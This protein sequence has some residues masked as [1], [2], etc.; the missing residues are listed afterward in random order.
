[1]LKIT[2]QDLLKLKPVDARRKVLEVYFRNGG[3][4]SRTSREIGVSRKTVRK[5]VRRYKEK[6][7]E[8]LRDRLLSG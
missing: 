3:N 7:E 5:V 4:I 1:M 2:Y 6:G 8:G